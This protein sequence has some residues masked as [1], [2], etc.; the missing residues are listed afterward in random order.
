MHVLIHDRRKGCWRCE[1]GV[2]F[3]QIPPLITDDHPDEPS[4]IAMHHRNHVEEALGLTHIKFGTRSQ[5]LVPADFP[6]ITG[7]NIWVDSPEAASRAEA[8]GF[9]FVQIAR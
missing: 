3:G 8:A 4:V 2:V 1:C 6:R 7:F 5:Q 9:P